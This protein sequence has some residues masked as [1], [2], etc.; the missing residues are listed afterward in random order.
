MDSRGNNKGAMNRQLHV[1]MGDIRNAGDLQ[2]LQR[3]GHVDC[4]NSIKASIDRLVQVKLAPKSAAV[5]MASLSAA[6]DFLRL[7]PGGLSN[8]DLMSMLA[9]QA[10]EQAALRPFYRFACRMWLISP[11]ESVVESMG[12][13]IDDVFGCHRQLDHANAD[14]ELQVRWNGPSAFNA[15]PIIDAVQARRG[16][17]FRRAGDI[18][19]SVQ[20]L[21]VR[22]HL[23]KCKRSSIFR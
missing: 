6:W 11:P 15:G 2:R 10:E 22:R 19:V 23:D 5:D 3:L 7:Q 13:V 12:S 14:M 8:Q 1:S 16:F 21:V 20:S 17:R 9:K 4:L 18:G